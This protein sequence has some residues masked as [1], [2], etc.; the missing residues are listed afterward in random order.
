MK[1]Y[2]NAVLIGAMLGAAAAVY[3]QDRKLGGFEE[4]QAGKTRRNMRRVL[5]M[6]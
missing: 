4:V 2:L 3:W 1:S 5:N 6:I